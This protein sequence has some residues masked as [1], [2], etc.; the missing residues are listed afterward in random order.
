[1]NNKKTLFIVW[2][3]SILITAICVHE[4]PKKIDWVK[5]FF[6]KNE[7]PI[8]AQSIIK[9]IEANAFNISFKEVLKFENAYRSAFV[10]YNENK[11]N[12]E[13]IFPKS[14]G[15]QIFAQ[16]MWGL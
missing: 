16:A 11:D 12:F 1:M 13:I 9:N 3:I 4:N 2:L 10:T 15:S 6:K 8:K 7:Q 14:Q 5:N